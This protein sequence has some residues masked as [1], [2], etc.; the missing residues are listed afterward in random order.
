MLR[1]VLFEEDP[2]AT[3]IRTGDLSGLGTWA[4]FLRMATQES[5]GFLEVERLHGGIPAGGTSTAF[6][7]GSHHADTPVATRVEGYRIVRNSEPIGAQYSEDGDQQG[8]IEDQPERW[9]APT[10]YDGMP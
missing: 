4:K 8:S 7:G 1:E 10:L 2:G 6:A 3:D 5:G 9:A